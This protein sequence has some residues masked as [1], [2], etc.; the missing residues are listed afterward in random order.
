M[1]ESANLDDLKRWQ[2]RRANKAKRLAKR[3]DYEA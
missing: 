1:A 2:T 3:W